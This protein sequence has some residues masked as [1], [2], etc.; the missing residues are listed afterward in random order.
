[1]TVLSRR[2]VGALAAAVAVAALPAVATAAPV[3]FTTA[4]FE[5]A[6]AAGKPILV[7][8]WA[9]WCPVCR[10]Q[11]PIVESLTTAPPFAGTAVFRVDFDAQKDVVRALGA[12]SQ[13]TLIVFK[14]AEER[15]RA[16]GIT[17]PAAIRALLD[18]SL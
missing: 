12:R 3:P 6:K 9:S 17:D 7:E 14:G 10:A 5:A 13:S 18:K 8:V 4:A 1:M 15:G 2:A 16:T 11:A